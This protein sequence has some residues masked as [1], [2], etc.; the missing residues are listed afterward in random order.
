MTLTLGHFLSLGARLFA[1]SVIGIF[2]HIIFKCIHILVFVHI[3]VA[4][5]SMP[6]FSRAHEIS[7][8]HSFQQTL[9]KVFYIPGPFC[10]LREC[11]QVP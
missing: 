1:L 7:C 9:I 3:A 10:M 4:D 2:L 6:P 11:S 8:G 5:P